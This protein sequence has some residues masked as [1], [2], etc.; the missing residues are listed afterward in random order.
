MQTTMST[1]PIRARPNIPVCSLSRGQDALMHNLSSN[2][3]R[4][5]K[6]AVVKA[7]SRDVGRRLRPGI[8]LDIGAMHAILDKD[9][10]F[11]QLVTSIRAK[12]SSNFRPLYLV[13]VDK[14]GIMR[15][16]QMDEDS[17]PGVPAYEASMI[18]DIINGFSIV[19]VRDD[20]KQQ[21]FMTQ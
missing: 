13:E 3:L 19:R 4:V 12:I 1:V 7:I 10:A 9:M 21:V 16:H 15:V 11:R 5:S 17:A 8:E 14:A 18:S 20:L 2:G 6:R